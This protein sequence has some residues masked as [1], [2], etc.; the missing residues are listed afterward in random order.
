MLSQ[1]LNYR[2]NKLQYIITFKLET[3]ELHSDLSEKNKHLSEICQ[4]QCWLDLQ[5]KPW[6]EVMHQHFAQQRGVR[7]SLQ[8]LPKT[9]PPQRL[10]KRIQG[11]R[12]TVP[13]L[14]QLES[15]EEQ[16]NLDFRFICITDILQI[17]YRY[18]TDILQI[19]YRYIADILQIYYRYITDILQIYYR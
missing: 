1:I 10:L 15:H 2:V 3:Q 12:P 18:I 8:L 11:E 17:Y 7:L 13:E 6:A 14:A 5:V 19:Y 9:V 4:S 16:G